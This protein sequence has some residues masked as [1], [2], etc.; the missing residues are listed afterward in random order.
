M[1]V[2]GDPSLWSNLFLDDLLP[3]IL[4]LVFMAWSDFAQPDR[5]DGEVPITR[6]FREHLIRHK[7]MGR[8]PF[9]IWSESE[10]TDPNTGAVIGR[11]DLRFLHGYREDVYFAF[12]CKRLNGVRKEDRSSLARL[13]V[14]EGMMRFVDGKYAKGL[15]K[16]GML[17][18]VMDGD[19]KSALEAVST[20]CDKN[21][22]K[23]CM[24]PGL[25]EWSNTSVSGVV[26]ESIHNLTRRKLLLYHIF[27]PVS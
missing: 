8:L 26:W 2:A 7:N 9:S 18:Y 13:Y 5:S 23:L 16:G 17:G 12:E 22:Q 11:I 10:E 27:L 14:L 15:D 6:R 1:M 19:T 21:V 3:K 20:A 4:D 25:T 24:H